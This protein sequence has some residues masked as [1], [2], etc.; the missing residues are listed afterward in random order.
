MHPPGHAVPARGFAL[1]LLASVLAAACSGDPSGPSPADHVTFQHDLHRTGLNPTESVLTPM[2]VNSTSFGLQHLLMVDGNVDAQPLYLTQLS[3]GGAKHNVVFAATE[4]DS[5]YAFDADRGAGL[6]QA[7]MVPAGETPSDA[8]NCNQVVPSIGVTAT[9]AIDRS[10]GAHGQI[11]LVAMT[12]D[13]SGAYHQRLHALDVTTGTEVAGSPVEI[14]ASYS[15]GGAVPTSFDPGQYEE[16]AALALA[17]GTIYT[18]WTSHCDG[19]PYHGWVIAFSE[20]TL[21]QTGALDLAASSLTGPSIWMAGNGPA[22]D[23]QGNLYVLTGNGGFENTLDAHGFPSGG[24]YG[25]SIVKISTGGGQLA[26]ADYFSPSN[27]IALS[28]NDQDLGS[29]GEL[30]LPDDLTDANGTV[31]HLV[32]GAGKEAVLYVADRESMGKFNSTTN[33]VWQGMAGILFGSAFSSP[34]YFNGTLYYCVSSDICRALPVVNAKISATPSSVAPSALPYP[35]ATPTISAN[36][37]ANAI[38][39]AHENSNPGVLHAYD[40]TNLANELYNSNQAPDGRDQFGPG[41]KFIAPA[42]SGGKVFVGTQ[43][44]VAVFGLL[45]K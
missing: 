29:G 23:A 40:A 44:S 2:N 5:V 3:V 16:R 42:V 37:T 30:L 15:L 36:G 26:V 12:K 9:P 10:A 43:N 34:A 24:D 1:L 8:R 32:V 22:V 38:L 41:N 45:A 6:W 35:G 18:S 33:N 20:K 27:T 17:N 25:N 14:S 13:A 4:N 7:S 19:P 28:A 11:F 31:R 21:A 39:W